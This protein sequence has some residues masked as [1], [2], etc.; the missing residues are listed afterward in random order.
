MIIWCD[1]CLRS[2]MFFCF[3]WFFQMI[4]SDDSLTG[5]SAVGD[6]PFQTIPSHAVESV[7]ILTNRKLRFLQFLGFLVIL[8]ALMISFRSSFDSFPFWRFW[9]LS[10]YDSYDTLQ[11]LRRIHCSG[12]LTE[13]FMIF[14]TTT[15]TAY[16]VQVDIQV[17]EQ[18][19][20][21]IDV[22]V[23]Q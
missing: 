15:C 10:S 17:G 22:Q 3:R 5:S 9:W 12:A 8:M 16:D 2:C 21:Y 23:V 19:D 13:L 7:L 6:S 4:L 14:N 20:T 18:V 1:D 11:T